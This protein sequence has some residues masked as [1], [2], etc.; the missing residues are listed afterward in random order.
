[1]VCFDITL[2]YPLQQRTSINVLQSKRLEHLRNCFNADILGM[3][4]HAGE[5]TVRFA[6]CDFDAANLLRDIPEPVYCVQIKI[7]RTDSILYSNKIGRA[8]V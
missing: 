3:G 6:V 8:H 4:T 7:L 1:M 2:A 5:M